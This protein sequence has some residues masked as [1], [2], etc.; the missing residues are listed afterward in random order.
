MCKTGGLLPGD[1]DRVG[2]DQEGVCMKSLELVAGV[3]CFFIV[4]DKNVSVP[5]H[6]GDSCLEEGFCVPDLNPL[7]SFDTFQLRIQR[8]RY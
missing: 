7:P 6:Q 3:I 1:L 5:E 8:C 4:I 2:Q